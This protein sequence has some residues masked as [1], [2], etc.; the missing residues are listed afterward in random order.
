MHH[1]WGSTHDNYGAMNGMLLPLDLKPPSVWVSILLASY[2]TKAVYLAECL[3]SIKTQKGHFGI[4]LVCIN[5]GSNEINTQF[6]ERALDKFQKTTRFCKIIYY[7]QS[8]NKG[9]SCCLNE[10][11]LL[12][13]NEIVFR[14]DADDIMMPHRIQTQL[15]FIQIDPQCKL[16]GCNVEMFHTNSKNEKTIRGPTQLPIS[17]TWEEYKKT[18]SHWIMA[19][20]TL[21]FKKSAVLEVGNY[22]KDT[23]M[24]EDLELELKILK[25]YGKIYNMQEALLQYRIHEDQI[26]AQGKSVT[27]YWVNR[28]NEMIDAIIQN[29]T[30]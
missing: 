10:G 20:P 5:D 16:I 17:L 29:E 27:P 23:Q 14:M 4:E 13:S 18:K 8:Q 3:E 22:N 11:L 26:T 24:C 15:N 6:L 9:L 30:I 28:R 21:C 1:E 2:N 7:K 12:C 19:H 25:K